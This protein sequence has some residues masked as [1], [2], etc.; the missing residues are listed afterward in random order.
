MSSSYE[1]I[2]SHERHGDT[3]PEFGSQRTNRGLIAF[4]QRHILPTIALGVTCG[5]LAGYLSR[6]TLKTP[7]NQSTMLLSSS[8]VDEIPYNLDMTTSPPNNLIYFDNVT[9]ASILLSPSTLNSH[10]ILYETGL[11]AQMNQAYCAVATSASVLNSLRY[12]KNFDISMDRIY[13]P[14]PYATQHDLMNECTNEKVI[15]VTPERDGVLTPPFGLSLEQAVKL[16]QCHLD[17]EMWSVEGRHVDPDTWT[18]D[19][20]REEMIGILSG[21]E[22]RVAINYHRATLGQVGGGHFSPIGGYNPDT[23]S[24]LILDVAKYKY[25]PVW[26]PAKHLFDSMATTDSCGTWNYPMAQDA[27]DFSKYTYAKAMKLMG[28]QPKFR[29]YVMVTSNE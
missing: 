11:D 29:G 18:V 9:A 22:G 21:N 13:D 26:A 5:F 16:L 27:I 15:I 3:N 23:D 14:Y 7:A 19:M 20:M 10:F 2:S 28:C 4:L 12:H 1:T 24:F 6:N 8:E 17:N 25:P